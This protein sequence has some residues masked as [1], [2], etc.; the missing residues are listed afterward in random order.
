MSFGVLSDELINMAGIELIDLYRI[1]WERLE[2][3]E[4]NGHLS[5]YRKAPNT[6]YGLNLTKGSLD[7]QMGT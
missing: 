3:N 6:Q 5:N 4:F 1:G 2:W 7:T